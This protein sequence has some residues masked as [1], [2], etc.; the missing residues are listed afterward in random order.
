M[1]QKISK[2]FT[3][4]RQEMS[5][6]SWPTREELRGSTIVV[7]TVSLIF[8]IFIYLIDQILSGILKVVY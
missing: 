6:V 2:F 4:V 3:E 1:F 5:K 8:A 7:I